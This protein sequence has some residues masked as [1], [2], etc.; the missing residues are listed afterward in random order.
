M[1]KLQATDLLQLRGG[2]GERFSHFMDRLIR[3]EAAQSGLAQAD[4]ATQLRV[5]IKDG[6]VDTEVKKAI[7]NEK[8]G[9]FAIPTAW[10]FKSGPDKG[11]S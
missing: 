9:W 10:Q 11:T 4:I 1:W 7:P 3:A 5:N 6:G 8:C 2:G